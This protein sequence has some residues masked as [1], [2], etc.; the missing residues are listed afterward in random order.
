[1]EPTRMLNWFEEVWHKRNESAIDELLH[2]DAVIHGL[3]TDSD[4]KGP[5]AFKPFYR[6]ILQGFSS[7]FTLKSLPFSSMKNLKCFIATSPDRM[8]WQE[9]K[10]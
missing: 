6:S 8:S 1:M 4:K 9:C 3:K 5:D 2:P 7:R 10:F